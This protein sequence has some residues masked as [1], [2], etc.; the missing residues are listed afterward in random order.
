MCGYHAGI[1]ATHPYSSPWWSWPLML[2][3]LWMYSNTLSGG[4]VSTITLMG[5]P[6]LWWGSIPALILIGAVLVAKT[7]KKTGEALNNFV[8]LFILVPFLLLWLSYAL[9]ARILFIY[10]F[11]ASVPFMIFAVTYWLQLPFEKDWSS[12]RTGRIVKGLVI[13]FLIV[14]AVL[15]VLFYPVISGYPVAYEY[16]ES[17]RWLSGW[18]F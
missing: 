11:V 5:N 16:K 4:M 6:A 10:H 17:L 8:S 13:A 2:K 3:P 14:V 12:P 15:F 9:I 18:T 1:D 7:I